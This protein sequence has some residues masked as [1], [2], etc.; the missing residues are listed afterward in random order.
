[1]STTTAL[2]MAIAM[3]LLCTSQNNIAV[4]KTQQNEPNVIEIEADKNSS[5][6]NSLH[7]ENVSSNAVS[8]TITVH[9]FK[10][11]DKFE[12]NIQYSDNDPADLGTSDTQSAID[13]FLKVNGVIRCTFD[14]ATQTFTVLSGPKTDLSAVVSTIN[15]K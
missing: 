1:M 9:T 6:I 3:P 5:D 2:F 14:K 15:K 7:I 11:I 13:A 12:S 10:V 8:S 4:E